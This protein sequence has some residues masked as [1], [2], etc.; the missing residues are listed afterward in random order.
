MSRHPTGYRDVGYCVG[1]RLRCDSVELAAAL[2]V[3]ARAIPARTALPVLG[4]VL[5]EAGDDL[6]L[7]AT[8]LELGIR[9]HLEADVEVEGALAVPGRLLTDFVA[10]LPA[11]PLLLEADEHRL[12]L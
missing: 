4:T 9:R 12:R 1:M 8:N 5:L 11:E 3:V 7:S 10:A 2:G 6:V